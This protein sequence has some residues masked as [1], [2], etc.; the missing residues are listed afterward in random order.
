MVADI[1]EGIVDERLMLRAE[2]GPLAQAEAVQLPEP[3]Q[4]QSIGTS[5]RS[6]EASTLRRGADAARKFAAFIEAEIAFGT[7]FNL[8][9]VFIG[10]GAVLY[11]TMTAEPRLGPIAMVMLAGLVT[12][13]LAAGQQTLRYGLIAI[14]ALMAGMMFAKIET[15]SRE[16]ILLGEQ[17]STRITG[18]LLSLEATPRGHK[19]LI[20]VLTTER[21]ALKFQPT[22]IKVTLRKMTDDLRP[23]DGIKALFLLR[24]PSGPIRPGSFDFGFDSYFDRIG[25]NGVSIS[26][27]ERVDIPV[28]G[29]PR[30]LMFW[31]ERQR[32]AIAA[33]IRS[34]I[35]GQSGEMS[36]ALIT[37]IGGGINAETNEAMRISGLAHVT[38]ISGLHMAL[39][40]GSVMGMIRLVLALFPNFASRYPIKKFAA[41]CALGGAF[42]YLL[43]SGGGVATVRS[44]IMLA[45]ML[46]AVLF[47]RAAITMRNLAIAAIIILAFA[48]H[49]IMGPSFQMSF[50]A[51]AALIAGYQIYSHW[52][53]QRGASNPAKLGLLQISLRMSG[54]FILG[55]FATSLV[56]G[57]ATAVYSAYHFNRI[58]PLGL[59]ANLIAMPA[60]SIIVMPMALISVILMPLGLEAGPLWMMGKGVDFMLAVARWAAGVSAGGDSGTVPAS[61]FALFTAA[62]LVFCLLNTRLRLAAAPMGFLALGLVFARSVPD[63]AISE[64][65]KLIAVRT[66]TG[67]SLNQPRPNRFTLDNWQR[68]Y[69]A[70]AMKDG[71]KAFVCDDG[72]CVTSHESGARIGHLTDNTRLGEA[73]GLVD[74]LVATFPV[75]RQGCADKGAFV[76]TARQLARRG[77][78]EV[79]VDQLSDRP[80]FTV[81]HAIASLDR[82]WQRHRLFSRAARNMEPYVSK[83][84]TKPA[85][86]SVQP[87]LD[88]G[89]DTN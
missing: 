37:G 41:S 61:A 19:A 89:Q 55:V 17:I 47:D 70:E 7:P 4:D 86:L 11:F 15:A 51:T 80:R 20:E 22:R 44:F 56:A 16:T 53:L 79:T 30:Q 73:C 10:L 12:A 45:V 57:L 77:A 33:S 63:L 26:A 67:L 35:G 75:D 24:P 85:L 31:F 82:P 38:S 50:A 60:V 43:L 74:F 23:G 14:A 13:V 81:R 9:P 65:A 48:P 21:P 83:R 68:A 40:A 88:G 36:A 66:E 78:A 46:I 25:A 71:S 84:K 69:Q 62:I 18:R 64:D 54:L 6:L 52:R 59:V 49:E 39:V 1:K 2:L 87:S 3:V 42:I 28:P 58:A 32:V 72:L 5:V 27:V 34:H 8:L 29:L 76:I